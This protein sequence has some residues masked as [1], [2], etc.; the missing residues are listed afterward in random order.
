MSA[1]AFEHLLRPGRIGPLRLSSR[2]VMPAMDMNHCDDGVITGAEIAHYRARAAGG[3]ALVITG[4]GAISFPIG[5]ASR[6]QPGLSD[7]RF[8]P[9]VARLADAVQGAGSLLCVQLTH[10]G[11]TARVD[12]AGDRPVL[13]P[14]CPVGKPDLSALRDNTPDELVRLAGATGGKLP[15]YREADEDDIAWLIGEFAA[16]ARR[17]RDAGADAVEVHAAHGYV[18]STF[19]A[20][21]DNR[22]QD[23]WGGPLENRARLT[24]EVVRAVRTAA[25]PE[26]AV[27]VR[28]SGREFG[29]DGALTLDESVSAARMFAEAGADAVH[30]TGWGRNS[31][32]NFTAGPLPDEVG[33][34]RADAKAVRAAV[35]VPVIAVGRLLPEVAEEMVAGGECDFVAMGRQLL[36]DPDLVAK[37][38][39][40][41]RS[42]IRPCI[43]CYVCVEQ[44]FYDDP[45]RCAV[46][47]ALGHED[48]AMLPP[49]EKPRRVVV[50]GGGPAGMEAARVA[51][52]RG[53]RVTLLEAADRLGGTAW[54]SQLTTP[55]NGPLLKWQA[56]ELTRL[57]VDVR[58][59]AT[60]TPDEIVALA[61]DAVVIATGARRELPP[62]PGADLPHVWT[63]DS[64]RAAMT[65]TGPAP[66]AGR[67]VGFVL[68]AAH[69][70][71]L[72]AG[73]A[74][75]RSLSRWWLPLG[76]RVVVLGGGLVGLEL[77]EFLAERHRSV[78]VLE[79]GPAAGL[80]MAAPRRWTAVRT[81]ASHGVDIVREATVVE[82]AV[83]EVV[84]DVG[85]SRRRVPADAVVI[86]DEVRAGAPLADMLQARGVEVH[87]IGDA[88]EVGY[89]EGAIH[90]AWRVARAI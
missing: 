30:V 6:K 85:D 62:V 89:I 70:L 45:P 49:V 2:I 3:A 61:P 25:G 33:A 16:A 88:G 58:T 74:R 84:Y 66:A 1:A 4:S 24:V 43:N 40:G 52:E 60:A 9:G 19:L 10:H 28:V 72:T 26:M 79:P 27:L 20:R 34:Y 41:R 82:I 14:S 65:G 8:V 69:A 18:L 71:R 37:L 39:T 76:R 83:D 81:A 90:S 73:M 75:V 46:N 36:T 17:V 48:L 56:D 7:D 59:G 67:G 11:K 12:I 13:V 23:R 51:G 64:L 68:R 31:F 86:A 50:V 54:F 44:N 35:G 55:A 5:A 29:E 53:H 87:V 63:G 77:A 15:A 78:T 32:S 47:P 42:S 22:R 57:G 80:P 21:A 38:R